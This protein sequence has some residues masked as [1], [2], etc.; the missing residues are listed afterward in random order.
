VR[1]FCL[2]I[3]ERRGN[4]TSRTERKLCAERR[5]CRNRDERPAARNRAAPRTRDGLP[6]NG[7]S[8]VRGVPEESAEAPGVGSRRRGRR[9]KRAPP[10]AAAVTARAARSRRDN[11]RAW[12]RSTNGAARTS[13]AH[14]IAVLL[15]SSSNSQTNEILWR[16]NA[17]ADTSS[18]RT[19]DGLEAALAVFK[20]WRHSTN[21]SPA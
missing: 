20:D 15:T 19:T 10:S 8:L 4:L 9:S 3:E 7:G 5:G 2:P 1:P 17:C 21:N 13:R 18:G 16:D 11:Q 14:P 12:R 6:I